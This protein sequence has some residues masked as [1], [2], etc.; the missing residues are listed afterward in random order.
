MPFGCAPGPVSCRI[1]E[2]VCEV[3]GLTEEE[4]KIVEGSHPLADNHYR[5]AFL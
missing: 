4:I 5:L 3:Y 1:D 2:L